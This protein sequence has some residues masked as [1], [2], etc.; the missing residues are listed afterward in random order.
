MFNPNASRNNMARR[1]RSHDKRRRKNNNKD[2]Y[3]IDEEKYAERSDVKR[4]RQHGEQEELRGFNRKASKQVV[5]TPRGENQRAYVQNLEDLNV[6]ITF[7][8]GPAGTGKT[9]L[10]TQVAAKLLI[11]GKIEKIVITRPAVSVDEQHGFLPGSLEKK[12]EPWLLPILDIL[13]EHYTVKDVQDMIKNKIICIE[14]LAYMR[15]R[16]FK[17]SFII[18]DEMQNSLPSQM[19]MLLTRIGEGSRMA[20]TGDLKQHDRTFQ[21][22]G[23]LDFINR[24]EQNE[25][26]TSIRVNTFDKGDIQRHAVINDILNLYGE[27]D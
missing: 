17:N 19:K 26:V 5:L 14:P 25:N 9:L 4:H 18:G 15:G 11:E 23:L 7:G 20:I 6:F 27:G 22:N 13:H 16:T 8:I 3:L 24:L 21:E 1:N 2:W 12:L 10:A